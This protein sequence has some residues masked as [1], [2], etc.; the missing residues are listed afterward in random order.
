[1]PSYLHARKLTVV[2]LGDSTT[3]GTPFFRSPLEAPPY[4]AGDP[5]G[6]Y[7]FWIMKKEN[8]LDRPE[9]C[10]VS[11]QRSDEIRDRLDGALAQK[12]GFMW[13]CWPASMTSIKARISRTTV[14]NLGGMYREIQRHACIP[15]A[16][17]VLP[18]DQAT[19]RLKPRK[20]ANSMTGLKITAV[21]FK[22]SFCRS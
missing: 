16:A 15:V 3:A 17:T 1:M 7:G 4:G 10:G 20:F 13:W 18:F 9:L 11:G 5:E 2:A 21:K 12:S 8:R 22:N 14:R 19:P 6:F